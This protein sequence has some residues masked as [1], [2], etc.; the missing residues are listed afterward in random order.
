MHTADQTRSMLEKSQNLHDQAE[1]SSEL[2]HS[3]LREK[4]GELTGDNCMTLAMSRCPCSPGPKW[5][6]W[7]VPAECRHQWVRAD[8]HQVRLRTT[9]NAFLGTDE[10]VD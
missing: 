2:R 1:G 8:I 3:E 7:D 6:K 10:M 9:P 4:T 5:D